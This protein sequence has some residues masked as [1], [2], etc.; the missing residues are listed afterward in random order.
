M[1]KLQTTQENLII[2]DCK[3]APIV[4]LKSEKYVDYNQIPQLLSDAFVAVEDKRFYS[5]NGID[6]VRIAGAMLNNVKGNHTQG[7]ST[8]TQ[9]LAKNVYYSSEQTFSRKFKEMQTA[10]K[11]EKMLSKEEIME[12]YLNMLYFGSGEYGVKNASLRFF[13]KSLDELNALECAML[14]GIVK[15]PTKY[16]PI[17]NYDNSIERA[18][19]VLKLMREQGKITDEIYNGYKNSDI[20]IKNALIENNQAKIYLLNTKYEACQILNIEE[21]DLLSKGYIISTFYDPEAQ[22]LLSASIFNDAYYSSKADNPSGIGIVCDNST[23]GIKALSSRENINIFEFKRQVGSTIKPLACYAPALDQGIISPYTKVLDEPTTFDNYSPSNFRDRY[24]GWI[25]VNECVEKSL[26]IPCVKVLQQLGPSTSRNYL[27]K[28]NIVTDA[29]DENLALALGGTTYGISMLNLLG[30]YSA[31]S[32]GG[33]YSAPTFV[34]TITDR[35]GNL[36]YDCKNTISNRVFDEQSAYLMTNMLINTAKNGTAKKLAAQNYQIACKTGTVSM[37]N[38]NFNSD[39]YSVGYTS[40]DTFLFWQGGK[41]SAEQTGGGA[42]T[43]MFKNFLDNYYVTAP[44]DFAVP[45]GIVQANIDKYAY[46][47]SNQVIRSSQNAPKNSV[48]S[49]IFSE[50]CLP[51]EIDYTYDRPA[52][53]DVQFEQNLSNVSIKFPINPKLCYKIYKRDF[54]KGETLLYDIKNSF[55]DADYQIDVDKFWGNTITVVPY[56]LDDD[57]REIIGIPSK[58]NSYSIISKIH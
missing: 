38:K 56:Y 30:G 20:I 53:D 23:L 3:G 19:I 4:D 11:L 45:G 1:S 34:K 29:N 15:S 47:H 49:C 16:N 8:I 46:E 5:H 33:L 48:I 32:N 39:I 52:V 51:K 22:K 55:G 41:L 18:R 9:Q 43:L 25:S 12:Y 7:A 40:Q 6:L 26:N 36:V 37:E 28:L 2:T 21:K 31:L 13:D 24:Y 35:D 42:T 14:A 58:Y 17:N 10:I 54:I 44:K 57:S 50:K 27:A